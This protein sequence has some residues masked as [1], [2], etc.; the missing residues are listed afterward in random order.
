M[1]AHPQIELQRHG[2]AVCHRMAWM[3]LGLI[4][5]FTGISVRLYY[6]Q[7]RVHPKLADE[8]ARLRQDRLTLP[9]L[10]GSIWD[11]NGQLLAQDRTLTRVYADKKHLEDP[12]VVLPCLAQLQKTTKSALRLK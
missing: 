5:G 3:A 11:A 10:R 4:V 7:V 9:S 8:A 2:R 6:L 1:S 12:R